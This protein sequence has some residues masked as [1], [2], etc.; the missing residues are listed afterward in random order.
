[1]LNNDIIFICPLCGLRNHY[2]GK[3]DKNQLQLKYKTKTCRFCHKEFE[4][5]QRNFSYEII[6]I[7][8]RGDNKMMR[9]KQEVGGQF[10]TPDKDTKKGDTEI[11]T[12]TGEGR[13]DSGQ[14]GDRL[15]IPVSSKDGVEK[16]FNLSPTNENTLIG[17]FG[18]DTK[19]WI[20]KEIKILYESCNVGKTGL[21]ITV[22]D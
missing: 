14:Y 1:M 22:L 21:K 13:I 11:Y 12:I 6:N 4:L 3:F 2:Y 9:K 7:D 18:E 16:E 19:N 15:V 8:M 5:N 17:L 20:D 10:L